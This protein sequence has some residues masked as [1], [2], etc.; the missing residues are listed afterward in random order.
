MGGITGWWKLVVAGP[1]IIGAV[2][3]GASLGVDAWFVGFAAVIF[4]VLLTVLGS[5]LGCVRLLTRRAPG[6]RT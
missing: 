5:I 4:A 1:L 2:I 6:T 3:A